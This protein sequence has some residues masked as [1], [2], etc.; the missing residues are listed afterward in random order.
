MYLKKEKCFLLF[1]MLG[2]ALFSMILILFD[3]DKP[4]C[5][6][7]LFLLPLSFIGL[8]LIFLNTYNLIPQNLGT[9][10]IIGLSFIRTVI[11][12]IIMS[13]GN[14]TSTISINLDKN[15]NYSILLVCYELFAIFCT[16]SLLSI[17]YN[18]NKRSTKNIKYIASLG[19]VYFMFIILS[20]MMAIIFCIITPGLKECF[21]TIFHIGDKTFSSI[22]NSYI[23]DKYSTN[24]VTKFSMVT[25]NY[26]IKVLVILIPSVLIIQLRKLKFNLFTKI[27]SI[28]ICLV[29]FFFVDGAIARSLIY[30]IT[31]FMLR[32]Y[33][34]VDKSNSNISKNFILLLIIGSVFVIIYWTIRFNVSTSKGNVWEYMSVKIS[35]YFSSVNIVSGTFNLPR[36]IEYRWRYFVYDYIKTIPYGNT[37]FPTNHQSIQFFFNGYNCSSGQIIPTIGASYYYFGFLLAP[38]Y[39]IVF[40]IVAYI[41]SIKMQFERDLLPKTRLILTIF[42]FSMGIVMYNI[43]ITMIS[44]FSIIIPLYLLEK[45][46]AK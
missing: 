35:S 21:R 37:L 20:L 28:I 42:Y 31:L 12:P 32:S 15:I 11:G 10:I 8:S 2:I 29:P 4:E 40:T 25:G 30:V 22:E 19:K 44:F 7:Y 1:S 5:Y 33:V 43:E 6:N 18:E 3:F 26:L 23:I 45:L 9:T 17:K 14:Y 13:L 36:T 27:I 46:N 24:M 34:F 41:S 38:I 16:L 39:S